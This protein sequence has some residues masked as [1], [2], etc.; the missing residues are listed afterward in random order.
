MSDPDTVIFPPLRPVETVLQYEL[1]AAFDNYVLGD[2]DLETE[3]AYAERVAQE[4]L[5]CAAQ[6]G[7]E[8][9]VGPTAWGR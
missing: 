7:V 1:N 5:A 8:A 2:A 9:C 3:L 6:S 4:F